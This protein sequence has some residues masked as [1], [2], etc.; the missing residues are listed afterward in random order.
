MHNMNVREFRRTIPHL[1]E[2]LAI[3]HEL[4]LFSRGEA[5]ARILPATPAK[6]RPK[7]ESLQWLRDMNPPME[8]LSETLVREDRDRRET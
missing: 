5:V 3:E 4:L 6:K 1:R 8:V 2:T 7:L